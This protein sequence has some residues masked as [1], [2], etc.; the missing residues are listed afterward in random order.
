[1]QENLHKLIT[2][3]T[4]QKWSILGDSQITGVIFDNTGKV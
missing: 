1:M 4:G 2:H 3:W